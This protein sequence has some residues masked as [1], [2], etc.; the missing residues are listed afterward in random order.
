MRQRSSNHS[1]PASANAIEV[2]GVTVAYRSYQERPTSLKESLIRLVRDRRVKHF[3]TFDALQDVSFVV[4]RGKVL[5]IIG[6]NGS[7]KSTLLKVLAQVLRP[8]QGFAKL[9]GTV[10]CLIELGAGFDPELNALEN[11]YLNGSLHKRTAKQIKRHVDSILDF[12]E[13]REFARTPIKYYSSG[14]F[15]RLGFSV[16]VDIDP[17]ILLVDEI[18]AVGDERFQ[19]KCLGVFQRFIKSGKTILLVSHDV[20][21][22]EAKTDIVLVLSK[23]KRIF[24]GSPP[25]AVSVYRGNS[26][27]TALG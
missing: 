22:I 25:E 24:F 21:M 20:A 14:M 7:G 13:L 11:I 27:Q 12:A 15:A 1:A 4:P 17:D 23:G 9:H 6:S 19:Q 8:T 2:E 3:S 26:Y 16:A 10:S 18:L 5:G